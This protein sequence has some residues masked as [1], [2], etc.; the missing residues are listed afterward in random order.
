MTD[1]YGMIGREMTVTRETSPRSAPRSLAIIGGAGHAA[2]QRFH[3]GLLSGFLDHVPITGDTDLPDVVHVGFGL[4][5]ADGHF[6]AAQSADWAAR[7]ARV[8][9]AVDP[10]LVVAV[11]N[12]VQPAL[13]AAIGTQWPVLDNL[14][15][16]RSAVDAALRGRRVWLGSQGAYAQGLFPYPGDALA[17][18][19]EDMILA[20]MNDSPADPH[21]EQLVEQVGSMTG[22]VL[23][24]TDLTAYAPLLRARGVRVVDAVEELIAATLARLTA[25]DQTLPAPALEA[26]R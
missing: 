26:A 3:A 12:T 8:L 16:V 15:V 18:L 2:A 17:R 20:G 25:A 19:A 4:G 5:G 23:A 13:H 22:V 24:C 11:C 9:T 7:N 10:T 21:V 14:T 1:T 6:T